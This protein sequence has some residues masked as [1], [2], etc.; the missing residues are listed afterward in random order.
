[1]PLMWAI[2]ASSGMAC[3]GMMAGFLWQQPVAAW[4]PCRADC[5][6]KTSL[7]NT[8]RVVNFTVKIH[9]AGV[10]VLKLSSSILAPAVARRLCPFHRPWLSSI[11]NKPVSVFTQLHMNYPDRWEWTSFPERGPRAYQ[12]GRLPAGDM[13]CWGGCLALPSIFFCH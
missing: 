8:L 1:M 4:P 9:Q 6:A 11:L 3:V 7:L 13:T 5:R 10:L 2:Q 12:A